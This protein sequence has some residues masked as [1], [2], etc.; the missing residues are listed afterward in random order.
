M[1]RWHAQGPGERRAGRCTNLK[2]EWGNDERY[3][4]TIRMEG[5]HW[6]R[7]LNPWQGEFRLN[8][9]GSKKLLWILD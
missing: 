4:Y 8:M 5:A 3:S 9:V 1:G 6:Q 2:M 7:N